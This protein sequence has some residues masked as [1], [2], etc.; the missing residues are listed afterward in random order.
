[1]EAELD[2]AVLKCK[3][4]GWS[5]NVV[6][7]NAA[8]GQ[9]SVTVTWGDL[10]DKDGAY[11]QGITHYEVRLSFDGVRPTSL[12]G[13]VTAMSTGVN[14]CNPTKYSHTIVGAFP[15]NYNGMGRVW[16]VAKTANGALPP[17]AVTNAIPDNKGTTGQTSA[18]FRHVLSLLALIAAL[19]A[20]MTLSM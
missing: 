14:C 6:D 12:M 2:V 1:M 10:V 5:A 13:A 11:V 15:A 18:T 3:A 17:I 20:Q 9:A 8:A 19:G 16:L 7:T 4:C